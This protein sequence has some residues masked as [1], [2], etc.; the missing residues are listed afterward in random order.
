MLNLARRLCATLLLTFAA[1]SANAATTYVATEA[2]AD[3]Y[4]KFSDGHAL[5]LPGL[6][7]DNK[8]LIGP[9][10][11]TFTL[12][13]SGGAT[14]TGSLQNQGNS[15]LAGTF[16]FIFSAAAE[17]NGRSGEPKKELIDLAYTDG[18]VDTDTWQYFDLDSGSFTGSGSASDLSLSFM[19]MP[20][21]NRPNIPA[22]EDWRGQF[23]I[24]ANG[25]NVGLGFSSWLTWSAVVGAGC[26][27]CG[28]ENLFD[29]ET[30]RGDINIDLAP[31]PVPAA[32]WLFGSA[33]IGFIG[34][35]RRVSVG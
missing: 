4:A 31:V 20:D 13:D 5:W 2:I 22:G 29:G 16:S 11:A 24:G 7:D 1:F 12:E 9:T 3:S 27:V 14:F 35:S 25:K 21:P 6:A 32:F 34:M 23:G 19:Q 28:S 15:A 17:I 33:L 30:G 18:S 10:G 8:W 26:T